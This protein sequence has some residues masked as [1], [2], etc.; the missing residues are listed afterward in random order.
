MC[1]PPRRHLPLHDSC[2]TALPDAVLARPSPNHI[3]LCRSV[4]PRVISVPASF[5]SVPVFKFP[6]FHSLWSGLF[7]RHYIL[8]FP[9]VVDAPFCGA[10][11]RGKCAVLFLTFSAVGAHLTH[12]NVA[13]MVLEACAAVHL[14]ACLDLRPHPLYPPPLFIHE[15]PSS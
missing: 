9:M 5:V 12:Q 4:T 10:S 13:T 3:S 1:C 2:S 14:I 8:P 6:V 15:P 11:G 7:I